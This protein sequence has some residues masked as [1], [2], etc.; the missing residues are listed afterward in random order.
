MRQIVT[1]TLKNRNISGWGE[2]ILRLHDEDLE[3][4]NFSPFCN[5]VYFM[6]PGRSGTILNL[7]GY[8]PVYV[9]F[10]TR[11]AP[12]LQNRII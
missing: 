4:R 9:I 11:K 12:F 8:A 5:D 1:L 2:M 6:I 10:F 3:E 7:P